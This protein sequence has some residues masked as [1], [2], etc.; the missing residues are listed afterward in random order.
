M[1]KDTSVLS[2]DLNKTAVEPKLRCHL[3]QSYFD[4]RQYKKEQHT[5]KKY[6][7]SDIKAIVKYVTHQENHAGLTRVNWEAAKRGQQQA[8]SLAN[9][10]RTE[11]E[12][13]SLADRISLP[14]KPL[15]QRISDPRP[16]TLAQRLAPKPILVDFKKTT[17]NNK[18]KVFQLRLAATNRRLHAIDD[19]FNEIHNNRTYES[20]R[21]VLKKIKRLDKEGLD[22]HTV[23]WSDQQW[24]SFEYGL[25][26]IGSISF[27]NLKRNINKVAR[28]LAECVTNFR[29]DAHFPIT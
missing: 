2:R 11:R 27:V 26:Q 1:P 3:P 19:R 29:L 24:R 12:A 6:T 22:E 9:R 21:E 15:A 28:Q 8:R 4:A 23:T 20:T 13:Q 16:D 14:P 7:D 18:I 10:F 17:L 25:K 5:L